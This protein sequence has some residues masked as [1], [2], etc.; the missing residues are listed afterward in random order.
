MRLNDSTL[1]RATATVAMLT[2]FPLAAL[3]LHTIVQG[4]SVTSCFF[5]VN[6]SF[7]TLSLSHVFPL[8]FLLLVYLTCQTAEE[9]HGG[10]GVHH[11][12]GDL[13]L[14]HVFHD[15]KLGCS[16]FRDHLVCDLLHFRIKFLEQ[17]FKKKR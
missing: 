10:N 3:K 17:I 16:L 14:A 12:I 6:V 9:T 7:M 13:V 2:R 8:S 1:E 5:D 15:V 11:A 4:E